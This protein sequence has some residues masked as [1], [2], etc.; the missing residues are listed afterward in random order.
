VDNVYHLRALLCLT[1]LRTIRW[2]NLARQR[3]Q[4]TSKA[5]RDEVRKMGSKIWLEIRL[6]LMGRAATKRILL[7][8]S[9][10]HG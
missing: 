9:G 7:R 5:K 8:I 2:V 6:T 10:F 1:P 3:I 4:L